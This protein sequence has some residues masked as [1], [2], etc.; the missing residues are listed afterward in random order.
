MREKSPFFAKPITNM[1]IGAMESNFLE[2]NLRT[3][4]AFLEDQLKTSPGGG[5]FFCGKMTGADIALS[6]PLTSAKG[7]AGLTKQKYP[8]LWDY[9]EML[10]GMEGYKRA[11]DK[12]VEV[13]GEYQAN[14]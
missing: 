12:V 2:P 4:F 13:E 9:I 7:R 14:L 1:I 8:K 3:H 11:I 5:K 10:E 6:F